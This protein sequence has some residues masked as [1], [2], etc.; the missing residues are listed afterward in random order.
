MVVLSVDCSCLG[1]VEMWHVTPSWHKR[2]YKCDVMR[3]NRILSNPALL[4]YLLQPRK[5]QRSIACKIIVHTADCGSLCFYRVL[6]STVLLKGPPAV[7]SKYVGRFGRSLLS[8]LVRWSV[9]M[10][11]SSYRPGP[12]PLQRFSMEATPSSLWSVS[13]SS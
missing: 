1:G 8:K 5:A 7:T 11:I 2:A 10:F 4:P 6:R 3:R 9:Q 13:S 12:H